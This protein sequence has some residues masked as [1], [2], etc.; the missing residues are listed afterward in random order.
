MCLKLVEEFKEAV[1]R[2]VCDGEYHH[3]Q[4]VKD[5]TEYPASLFPLLITVP[6]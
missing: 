6:T 5:S 1:T 3:A 4:S 2:A